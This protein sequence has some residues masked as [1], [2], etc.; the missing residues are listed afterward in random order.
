MPNI[1]LAET[2]A[3]IQSC[4]PVISVLRPH[5]ESASFIERIRRQQHNGYHLAGLREDDVVCS[6]AGFRLIECLA[7]GRIL[8]VDDLVT[9]PDRQ[10]S[11]YGGQ[12]LDWLIVHAR[13]NGCEQVHLDSGYHR[14]G[15]HRFYLR[16]GFVLGSHHFTLVLS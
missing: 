14:H 3:E 1:F 12:L 7:W 9:Q 16:R 10:G 11:G 4:F 15:A 6:A 2:D 13:A 5:L 8:Y